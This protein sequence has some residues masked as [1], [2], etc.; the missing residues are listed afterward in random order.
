MSNILKEHILT[1]LKQNLRT[2]GRKFDEFRKVE[3][4]YGISN[5]AEGSARV[6]IGDTEVIAGVK[7][8][9]GTPFPDNSDEGSIM[10]NVELRPFS[11]PDFV[12]G[13][14][15]TD[16]I[17]LARVV[18]RAIREAN[19]LDF[20]KLC[21]KEGESVWMV[22]IDIYPI[23][24]C[25]NLFDA[26]ALCALAALQDAKFPKLDENNKID[27]KQKTDKKIPLANQPLSCTV[28]KIGENLLVDLDEV[29]E[30]FIDAR[31]TIGVLE[32]GTLCALQKGGDTALDVK[33]IEKMVDLAIK[34][35][36][37][38]RKALK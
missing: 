37:E 31:L 38:L 2:D 8:E 17:E 34:K 30:K 7:V 25:G 6:K 4:E 16:A 20:K 11:S 29:E 12:S 33:D 15:G 10:V 1:V 5:S 3:V 27:Y 18:D 32:D 36:K 35:T 13:P 28:S 19:A 23:N 24:N 22:L 26:S 21:I 14:P 9:V